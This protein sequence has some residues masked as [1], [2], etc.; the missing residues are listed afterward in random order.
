MKK[1]FWSIVLLIP[2]GIASACDVCSSSSM[3]G[4]NSQILQTNQTFLGFGFNSVRQTNRARNIYHNHST[5]LIAAHSFKQRWQIMAILPFQ[6]QKTNTPESFNMETGLGDAR[7]LATYQVFKTPD[8]KLKPATHNLFARAGLKLPTGKLVNENP[9]F[10]PLGTGSVDFLLSSQYIFERKKMGF[11]SNLDAKV[12]TANKNNMLFGHQ[13]SLTAFY[14]YKKEVK[15]SMLMPFAG[16]VGEYITKNRSNGF[17]RTFSG[18]KAMYGLVGFQ[19]LINS[20][21]SL[22]VTG[23]IPLAQAYKSVEGLLYADYR[24]QATFSFIFNQKKKADTAAPM[25]IQVNN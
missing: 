1:I 23:E 15:A 17:L 16:A 12:N 24:I 4:L 25:N 10:M 19:A 22:I 11:N 3:S 20:K 18:G 9:E 21:Y 7:I 8:K 13:F 5:N 2:F 14:F 6:I